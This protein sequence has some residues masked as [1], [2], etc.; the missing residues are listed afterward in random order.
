MQEGGFSPPLS[1]RWQLSDVD[2]VGCHDAQ[3]SG[4]HESQQLCELLDV[5]SQHH[6]F[7]GDN[8]LA[9]T[10]SNVL[11]QS[12]IG[13]SVPV[14]A[15]PATV[16]DD[17][18]S[19][20]GEAHPLRSVTTKRELALKSSAVMGTGEERDWIHGVHVGCVRLHGS[21]IGTGAGGAGPGGHTT[22]RPTAI[23]TCTRGAV[24]FLDPLEKTSR[25]IITSEGRAQALL[26]R[27]KQ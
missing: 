10:T 26:V 7:T 15:P 3:N 2:S 25:T 24:P 13:G 23:A 22:T 16:F 4:S 17:G 18:S 12:G 21:C 6:Q 5:G 8:E 27:G 14:S 1:L 19:F 11:K 9:S 20:Q